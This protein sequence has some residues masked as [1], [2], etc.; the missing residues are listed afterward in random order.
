MQTSLLE[1]QIGIVSEI[2]TVHAV[3]S[4]ASSLLRWCSKNIHF[5]T[6]IPLGQI[7][8]DFFHNGSRFLGPSLDGSSHSGPFFQGFKSDG[9]DPVLVRDLVG[10]EEVV[11]LET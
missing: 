9:V 1:R 11:R 2:V 10:E 3:R 8:F 7:P 5:V 6:S 4:S